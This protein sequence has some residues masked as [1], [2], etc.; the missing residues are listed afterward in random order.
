MDELR[1]V[2]DSVYKHPNVDS[3][4]PIPTDFWDELSESEK[5][6]NFRKTRKTM[7]NIS[8][9]MSGKKWIMISTNI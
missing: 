8:T 2:K 6:A 4:N 9:M 7:K 5:E 3:E 1:Q